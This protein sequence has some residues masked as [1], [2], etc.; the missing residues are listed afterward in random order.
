MDG[1]KK[2]LLWGIYFIIIGVFMP[3]FT[4]ST[5]YTFN[6]PG[7]MEGIKTAHIPGYYTV[8]GIAILIAAVA[9]L[10]LAIIPVKGKE[11]LSRVLAAQVFLAAVIGGLFIIGGIIPAIAYF[12]DCPHLGLLSL[13]AGSIIIIVS[14]RGEY[15]QQGK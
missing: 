13:L 2:R 12:V 1:N 9:M 10:V 5:A 4:V 3:W 15:S 6:M 7:L 14:L 8:A 11:L